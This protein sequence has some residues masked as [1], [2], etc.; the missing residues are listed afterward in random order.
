MR[1]TNEETA[2]LA[3]TLLDDT[4]YTT[5]LTES[6]D[7]Y[8]P[9]GTVLLKFRKGCL[10]LY[11][12][13]AAYKSLRAAA[14]PTD[15]RGIAAGD[16][17]L[18]QAKRGALPVSGTRRRNVKQDG[19]LSKITRARPVNSGIVGYMER[20][21]RQPYCRLTAYTMEHM[22]RFRAALPMIRAVDAVFRHEMPERHAAQAAAAAQAP[23]F[24]IPDT[25][26]STITVNKNWQTAVHQ[27]A[28]D[29]KAG[30]GCMAVLRS[31][32]YAGGH[33][34]FPQYRVAVEMQT[35][36]ALLADVHEWHGNTPIVSETE[37]SERISCVFYLRERMKTCG[38]AHEELARAQARKAG[39]PLHTK[40]TPS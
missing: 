2:T 39:D 32:R 17:G 13:Q 28:G 1:L 10:P 25:A 5:L 34:V 33:L 30:F 22:D 31:G 18:D 14:T 3:G 19:T 21:V 9:D 4:H 11:A 26:F 24:H 7:L 27:D 8:R 23:E 36:D 29:L 15:N 37:G 12:C 35:R 16:P 6:A 20:S 40:G 38:T